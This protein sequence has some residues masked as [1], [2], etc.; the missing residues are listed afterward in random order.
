MGK[1][2]E[3]DKHYDDDGEFKKGGIF[4]KKKYT[5]YYGPIVE[6]EKGRK[7]GKFFFKEY[8]KLGSYNLIGEIVVIALFAL[9]IVYGLFNCYLIYGELKV[10]YVEFMAT[11]GAYIEIIKPYLDEGVSEATRYSK[12][13]LIIAGG[14]VLIILAV[15][16]ISLMI[17]FAIVR[18]FSHVVALLMYVSVFLQIGMLVFLY[19]NVNWVYNWIFL[20]LLIP[21]VLM[22]TFWRKKFKKAIKSLKMGALAVSKQGWQLL[23]PQIVQSMFIGVMC[24]LFTASSV[25]IVYGLTP[26]IV[27]VASY[28]ISRGYIYF[29]YACLFVFC[30]YIVY[31][32]SQGMK[33][34]MIHHWYRGGGRMGFFSSYNVIRKRWWGL[35]GYAFSSTIIHMLQYFRKML[36]GE[37]G[38]KNL[39]EAFSMTGELLPGK[40][41]SFKAK[42]GTPWYERAWMGLNTFTL[43][44]MVIE[45]RMFHTGIFRSLYV[46]LRDIAQMYIKETHIKKVLIFLEYILTTVNMMIGAAAGYALAWYLGFESNTLIIGAFTGIGAVLFLWVAGTT[47][48]LVMDDVNL[49]YTTVLFIISIDEINKKEGYTIDKLELID[50]K[51][52]LVVDKEKRKQLD[53]EEKKRKKKEKK[54]EKKNKKKDKKSEDDGKKK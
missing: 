50:G 5:D 44:A 54:K 4:K 41:G 16:L 38:P 6:D 39:G 30:T 48:T 52:R 53:A 33:I 23:M 19:M 7:A 43:P 42:K 12:Q 26:D 17:S 49:A 3:E 15:Y 10:R 1:K 24:F 18:V 36:K 28:E 31:Y 8:K 9:F 21:D 34:L 40:E 47:T 25:S 14:L 20:V 37:F 29:G 27:Y 13:F 11:N 45:D 46:M 32:V 35:L 2:K 51:P 22:L